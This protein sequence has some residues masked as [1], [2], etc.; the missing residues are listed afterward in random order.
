VYEDGGYRA[1]EDE[2]PYWREAYERHIA[3]DG[4]PTILKGLDRHG[5]RN[6]R[7]GGRLSITVLM[8]AMDSG[9]MAGKIVKKPRSGEPVYS[10]GAHPSLLGDDTEE[11]W[12]AYLASRRTR[13]GKS[14][15][16]SPKYRISGLVRCGDCSAAMVAGLGRTRVAG[17]VFECGR[18]RRGEGGRY[19]SS[20]RSAIEA[21][22]LE[23]LKAEVEKGVAQA[24]DS[25]PHRPGKV[26]A[27]VE[28]DVLGRK[29]GELERQLVNLTRQLA[30]E[31]IPESAYAAT[32]DEILE[33]KALLQDSLDR[34]V[35][36][37]RTP[38]D[39]TAIATRLVDNWDVL[40]VGEC[41]NLLRKLIRY[42]E[43]IPASKKW[44]RATFRV[45]PAWEPDGDSTID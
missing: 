41:R 19:V 20:V 29:L 27:S 34:V 39:A 3:G 1:N 12:Q 4:F 14:N 23:W 35:L 22:L 16:V 7:T 24:R 33:E 42:V 8:R 30:S 44:G 25:S 36:Q 9:F 5:I 6:P 10:Q 13:R 45:V 38:V 40:P 31:L 28:R 2:A 43:V 26:A 11:V 21:H 32:R 15:D 18:W 37:N 17:Y